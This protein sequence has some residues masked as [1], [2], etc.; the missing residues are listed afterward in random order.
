MLRW[1][2]VNETERRNRLCLKRLEPEVARHQPFRKRHCSE[3][4]SLPPSQTLLALRA[5]DVWLLDTSSGTPR[6]ASLIASGHESLPPS[7]L[8]RVE[9]NASLS[10]VY[11][12]S[13]GS[14]PNQRH[15]R[16]APGFLDEP[17]RSVRFA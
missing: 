15:H 7:Q 8:N 16:N 2:A 10:A 9:N 11:G 5:S 17:A 13:S 14:N 6:F 4:E 1:T 12:R 3:F